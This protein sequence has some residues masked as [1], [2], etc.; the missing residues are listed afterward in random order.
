MFLLLFA[1]VTV[2]AQ[3][4]ISGTVVDADDS[5]PL[6]NVYVCMYAGERLLSGTF[7]DK[8]GKFVFE[9]GETS[10]DKVTASL[11]GFALNEYIVSNP[12]APVRLLMRRQS[13]DLKE[14]SVTAVPIVRENDTVNYYMEAFRDDSDISL[15]QVLVKL[16]GVEVAENGTIYHRGKAINK[17]YIEGLDLLGGRYGVATQN[18]D[19]RKIAKIQ[20]IENHQPIKA[21]EGLSASDRSAVNIVLKA[22]ARNSWLFS[23]D[24]AA[25]YSEDTSA[26][27]E[28]R[29]W[30]ASFNKKRQNMM[31]LKANN[32]GKN[33]LNE[34][35]RKAYHGR[36]DIYI[37][38]ETLDRDFD[39]P[40][41]QSRKI[42]S[43]PDEYYFD[44]KSAIMSLN[45]LSVTSGGLQV[46]L[47][48]Q[49][50]VERWE[51]NEVSSQTIRF[52]DEQE[53]RIDEV[54]DRTDD[55][56]YVDASV[57]LESNRPRSYISDNLS[58]GGQMRRH[59]SVV[60]S[61]ALYEQRYSLPSLKI[62]N[63]L[64]STVRTGTNAA[65]NIHNDTKAVVNHHLF[66]LD[67]SDVQHSEYADVSNRTAVSASISAGRFKFLL[68][69]GLDLGYS[70]R[71]SSISDMPDRF[72]EV[73]GEDSS[74]NRLNVLYVAPE[75]SA[76]ALWSWKS[77]MM[78]MILP[79]GLRY[80]HGWEYGGNWGHLYPEL[81]P[82]YTFTWN[83]MPEI[84]T[85]LSLG[86][87]VTAGDVD[88]LM[89]GYIIKTYRTAS[90]DGIMPERNRLNLGLNMSYTSVMHGLSA[91]LRGG[92]TD[93]SSN[94]AS[95][96]VYSDEV[97][98]YDVIER[99]SVTKSAYAGARFKKWFGVRTFSMTFDAEY[100]QDWNSMF[101]QGK[102]SEYK[103]EVWS[104]SAELSSH[105]AD[106][107]D[108][109]ASFDYG[110]SQVLNYASDPTHSF[111]T[112]GR[113]VITPVTP[114]SVTGSIYHMHQIIPG[115]T[116]TN[117]PLIK[118]G[119]EYRLKKIRIFV[120][121]AN[122]LN[123]TEYRTET[124]NDYL[125]WTNSVRMRPRSYIAGIRMSF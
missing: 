93:G 17:F 22:D 119:A 45:H 52:D 78:E 35:G 7:S 71:Y 97:S 42:L 1:A 113:L 61:A 67:V 18:L 28:G 2:S 108:F 105:P 100:R 46:R 82:R 36:Q 121:C 116:V 25:G 104:A 70:R 6:Q 83:I 87:S 114:F 33:L 50:A 86:Y 34:I 58:I 55:R 59:N 37:S 29:L 49:G 81:K 111:R 21:L 62:E 51:E 79:A 102:D 117:T 9:Y 8:D 15:K 94:T 72:H 74:K 57:N 47:G 99:L 48:L 30:L 84:K 77:I 16:P 10:P 110:Y 96:M 53:L 43:I 123:S 89:T 75:V 65:L 112:E 41:S 64:A 54:N 5:R 11:L 63:S 24:A 98:L 23:A 80:F 122:L 4:V 66:V 31:L 118:V 115:G 38:Y 56:I 92:Y 27:A 109:T 32:T 107:L 91:V 101:L 76:Y 85:E 90:R 88:D 106:W 19:P 120:E 20:L 44:N 69:G 125:V 95:S 60:E 103:T 68:T 14:V 3:N 39:G 13:L 12:S 40:F 124:L 73:L 26:V